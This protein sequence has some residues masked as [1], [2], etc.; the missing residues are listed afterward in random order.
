[1]STTYTRVQLDMNTD[2]TDTSIGRHALEL[3]IATW[4]TSLS[5]SKEAELILNGRARTAI[6]MKGKV[7]TT[8]AWG[9]TMKYGGFGLEYSENGKKMQLSCSK[10]SQTVK[11]L[12][13]LI[14]KEITENLGYLYIY[15][16][17]EKRV[18]SVQVLRPQDAMSLRVIEERELL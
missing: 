7:E 6:Y 4:I 5:H 11:Y 10:L 3:V 17:K 14:E 15:T 8:Y 18:I 13:S 2:G 16:S 12:Q 9:S 1:M